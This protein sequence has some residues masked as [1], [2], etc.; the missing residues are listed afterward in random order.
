[1]FITAV[2][3][4]FLIKLRWPKNKSI[5][6]TRLQILQ[7]LENMNHDGYMA[8]QVIL[9]IS[10]ALFFRP[11]VILSRTTQLLIYRV[12]HELFSL[13]PFVL[14][15]PLSNATSLFF[16]QRILAQLR[17]DKTI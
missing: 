7:G 13:I 4:L 12:R 16:T 3:V 2:C 6:D 14:E 17:L 1:M 9:L 5:Y 8:L 15:N 10:P 11:L